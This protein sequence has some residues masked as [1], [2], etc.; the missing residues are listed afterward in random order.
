MYG[1]AR[2]K[3]HDNCY[4]GGGG[5]GRGRGG[6]AVLLTFTWFSSRVNSR[7]WWWWWW[8]WWRW[9]WRWRWRRGGQ[10]QLSSLGKDPLVLLLLQLSNHLVDARPLPLVNPPQPPL[11]FLLRV[12]VVPFV[13]CFE[14]SINT[15]RLQIHGIVPK[16]LTHKKQLLI[17]YQYKHKN[18]HSNSTNSNTFP[19]SQLT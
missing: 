9:R 16:C 19:H 17:Q 15:Y 3:H 13:T 12:V 5:G 6:A 2:V 1:V 11:V 7:G 10:G 8:R 4:V 14:Q 18:T